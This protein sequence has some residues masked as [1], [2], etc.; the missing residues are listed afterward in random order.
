MTFG[1]ITRSTRLRA[2]LASMIVDL[3]DHQA[4]TETMGYERFE[5]PGS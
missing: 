2:R 3:P 4:D 5:L 1:Q